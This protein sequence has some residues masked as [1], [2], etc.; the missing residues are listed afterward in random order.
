MERSLQ[1][2]REREA[3]GETAGTLRRG[4]SMLQGTC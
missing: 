3:A 4:G 1:S 2:E